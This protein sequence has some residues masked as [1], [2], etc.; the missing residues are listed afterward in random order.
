MEQPDKMILSVK[1]DSKVKVPLNGEWKY[2]PVAEF[3]DGKFYIYDLAKNDFPEQKKT[4][5]YGSRNS[6]RHYLMEW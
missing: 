4:C 2:Q 6:N 5:K 1:S 3:K